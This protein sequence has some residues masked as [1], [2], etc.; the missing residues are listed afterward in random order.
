M[1]KRILIAIVS[2]IVLAVIGFYVWQMWTQNEEMYHSDYPGYISDDGM[3]L[4]YGP[5]WDREGGK[6]P[7]GFY[8]VWV[9]RKRFGL[10]G[11]FKRM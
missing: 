3:V 5:D 6:C 4:V 11:G 9:A 2:L 8:P 7:S 10:I 1:T